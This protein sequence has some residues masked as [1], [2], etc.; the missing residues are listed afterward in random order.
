MKG[1]IKTYVSIMGEIVRRT[2]LISVLFSKKI[3]MLYD[4]IQIETIA[5]QIRM[6][7]E[8]IAL[9]S[10]SANKTLF[11][12]EG[13]KFK[14]F[15]RADSI[16]RDIEK[17]NPDFYPQPVKEQPVNMSNIPGLHEIIEI[18]TGFMTRSEIIKVHSKCCDILHAKNPYG[19]SKDHYNFL[20]QVP[21]WV[22]LIIELLQ[23]HKIRLLNDSGF[24]LVHMRES[25]NKG[26]RARAYYLEQVGEI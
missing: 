12:Q 16:F 1:D 19:R 3:N 7:I 25:Y 24:Y 20:I 18:K 9:A 26:Y 15:W 11:E 5:L 23:S 6:I 8:S 10:L 2:D 22:T 17:K 13:D 14:E 21:Q 4:D